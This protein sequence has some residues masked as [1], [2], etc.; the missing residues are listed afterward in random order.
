LK[1]K[2][3]SK[4]KYLEEKEKWV[5]DETSGTAVQPVRYIPDFDAA[6]PMVS[7]SPQ[8]NNPYI[9]YILYRNGREFS[10]GAAPVG[11]PIKI[12]QHGSICFSNTVPVSGLQLK[13]D[14]GIMLVWLGFILIVFGYFASLYSKHSKLLFDITEECRQR[15]IKVYILKAAEAE[16]S[17]LAKQFTEMFSQ[18]NL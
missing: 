18:K 14:P 16:K 15:T 12:G 7:R 3:A 17:K 4:E 6:R 5:L 9:L 8:P 13:H 2:G 1:K 11:T 10:W